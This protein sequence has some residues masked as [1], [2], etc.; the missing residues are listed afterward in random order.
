MAPKPPDKLPS[1]S[2]EEEGRAELPDDL[3]RRILKDVYDDNDL[4]AF[5]S[6]C[7]QAR[8]AQVESGRELRTEIKKRYVKDLARYV[9]DLD[10]C[11]SVT[12]GWLLWHSDSIPVGDKKTRGLL[13]RAAARQGHVGVLKH[14]K[15]RIPRPEDLFD[16]DD[17]L[18]AA[19]GGQLEALRWLRSLDPPCPWDEERM[20]EYAARGGNLEL[21]KFVRAGGCPWSERVCSAAARSGNLEVLKCAG[22]EDCPWGGDMCKYAAIGGNLEL[23]KFVREQCAWHED[24]MCANAAKGGSVDLLAWVRDQGCPMDEETCSAAAFCGQLET[25]WWLRSLDPPCPWI[26]EYMCWYAAKAGNLAMLQW[27]RAQGCP[28]DESTTYAA[29]QKGNIEILRWARSQGCPLNKENCRRSYLY[30]KREIK[31]WIEENE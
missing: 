29:A 7:K 9:W 20:C 3:W 23:L 2:A 18:Q 25:L 21:L 27:M 10:E 11:V 17:C 24:E 19:K 16:T 30:M 8:Q 15:E 4:F 6:L 12:E 31:R 22:S 26:K 5:A 14:W 1:S 28:W 13:T